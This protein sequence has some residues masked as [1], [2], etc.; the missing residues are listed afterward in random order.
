MVQ[1]L[2]LHASNVGGVGLISGWENKIPHAGMHCQKIKNLKIKKRQEM[3]FKKL[4]LLKHLGQKKNV[5]I[6]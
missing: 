6:Y 1:W 4:F 3:F 2:R 5:L